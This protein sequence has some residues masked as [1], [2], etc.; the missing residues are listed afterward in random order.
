MLKAI[1]NWLVEINKPE[2]I[3]FLLATHSTE[4]WL[5]STYER[6][7]PIFS[8]LTTDFDFEEIEN[9]VDRLVKLG[10]ATH[11]D[12]ETGR[13]KLTKHENLYKRYANHLTAN[14]RKVRSECAEVESFC[15]RLEQ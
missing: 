4:T 3:H 15:E 5:L 13:T 2:E 7:H 1:L 10:Y 12:R 8:D 14:L 11:I 9:V 6:N